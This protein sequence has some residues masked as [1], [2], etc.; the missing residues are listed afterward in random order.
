M[1]W[2]TGGLCLLAGLGVVGGA[3]LALFFEH[4]EDCGCWPLDSVR[5]GGRS[6]SS[7]NGWVWREVGDEPFG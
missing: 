2:T 1:L 5:F 4:P 3:C 6:I 7:L